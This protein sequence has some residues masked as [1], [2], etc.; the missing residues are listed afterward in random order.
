MKKLT[1]FTPT[2]NR[3]YCLGQLYESLSRQTSND[4]IWLII[5]DGSTDS[6]KKTVEKCIEESE[7]SIKYH[8]QDNLGM[9]GGHNA[10]YR[11]I[12][13]E[14]NVCIDSDDYMTDDGIEKIIEFWSINGSKEYSGIIALDATKDGKILGEKLPNKKSTTLKGYYRNGGSGDKKLVYRTEVMKKYPEYPIF[15]GEKY[16]GLGYK[17]ILA[18]QE[19]ELLIMNE[20][21]CIVEYLPDGSSLNMLKQYKINPNG[22]RFIRLIKMK[23]ATNLKERLINTIHFVSSSLMAKKYNLFTDSPNKLLTFLAF[24]FGVLLYLYIN[25]KVKNS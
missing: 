22:F 14:L 2:Y 1:V 8:Y 15:E 24:P 21:L 25:I 11:L 12:D 13:T 6:T 9:H 7:F 10:A 16:V 4:F 19:Y 23:Y 3:A 20:I 18:D 17:Y 5:D